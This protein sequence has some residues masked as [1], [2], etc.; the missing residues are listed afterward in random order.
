MSPDSTPPRAE[1]VCFTIHGIGVSG[2][3]AVGHAHLFHGMSTEVAH[4]E[5]AS[6]DV[7]REQRRY[8]RAVKEVRDE[9]QALTDDVLHGPASELAPFV[10][11]HRMLLEDAAVSEAPRDIIRE[12]RCNAEWAL[13]QQMEVLLAQFDEID[14]AYLRERKTD[15]KQ[16]VE[17]VLQALT[18]DAQAA[19]SVA[20]PEDGSILVA[21]DLSPADVI[22]FKQHR[23]AALRSIL[24]APPRTPRSSPAA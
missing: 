24:A 17:R 22:L 10:N 7:G 12:Q 9:L 19:A 5:I 8:D 15:V 6:H 3:I 21:H 16:V 1:N 18:R 2:G 14:D 13:K 20:P 11:V 4:Y 23:F